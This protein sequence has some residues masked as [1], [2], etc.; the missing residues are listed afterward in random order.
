METSAKTAFNVEEV[1]FEDILGIKK[2]GT[3]CGPRS[4]LNASL[5]RVI[6][7]ANSEAHRFAIGFHRQ[8]RGKIK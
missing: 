5:D 8:L 4:D 3:L 7:L 6:L 2:V 1:N